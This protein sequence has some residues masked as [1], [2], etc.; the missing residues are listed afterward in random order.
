VTHRL[1]S[2][3]VHRA[4]VAILERERIEQC[5]ISFPSEAP[6]GSNRLTFG[7]LAVLERVEL[8][9][10]MEGHRRSLDHSASKEWMSV[11][12]QRDRG[13]F[14]VARCRLGIDGSGRSEG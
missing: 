3:H 2:I 5:P 6:G 14:I 13:C 8:V 1:V 4:H 12:I 9:S 11:R 7:Y 10:Y